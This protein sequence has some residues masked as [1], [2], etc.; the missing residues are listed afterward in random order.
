MD[1]KGILYLS[2]DDV[3]NVLDLGRAIEITEQALRDHS[4]GRVIWS[5]P[6]DLAIKPETGWQSWVTGCAL[7]TEPVAG[8]RIRS[9]KAAGG[10]RDASRAPRGPRRILILGDREGGEIRAIMD[11]D[12]CH[13]VRT[14]AAAT[15]A[16]RLLARKDSA[17]MAML[18]AGD[19]ARA[20]VPVMAQAFR[21]KEIRVTSRTPASRESYAKEIGKEYSLNVRPVE[22]TEEALKGADVVVSATTTST[23]FVNESWLGAGIT[24]YSIGKNQEM[25]SEVY[26]NCD[27]FVVDS[28]LHCKNKSD[29][30][31][32]LKENFLSEKDL[33]AELPDLLSGKTPGR[34]SDKE[35]IFIR[36]I[37]LV[38]QDIAMANWI[39]RA[40]LERSVG[41]RLPY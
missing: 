41:T 31:R 20:A 18:G 19:T 17:V 29:M 33:Y 23:P 32:L 34:Q 35:R 21:L 40:A 15:V 26:K 28:W 16:M 5:T 14:A 8:F 1:Q 25:E 11:E 10:S 3:K 24:V 7:A 4:E 38:N 37:G 39:Y 30:Q 27:K 12:W 9:I 13:A 22:S 36:A 6:E 2:N